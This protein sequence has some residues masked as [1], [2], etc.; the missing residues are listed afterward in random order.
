MCVCTDSIGARII[1]NECKLLELWCSEKYTVEVYIL[2]YNELAILSF[3]EPAH[4]NLLVIHQ[5]VRS[6]VTLREVKLIY[7]DIHTRTYER[8]NGTHTRTHTHAHEMICILRW[9]DEN[10]MCTQAVHK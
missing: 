3:V 5:K 4:K 1:F 7:I 10:L 8:K 6:A 9:L 2:E